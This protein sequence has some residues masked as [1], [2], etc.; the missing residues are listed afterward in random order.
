MQR[1]PLPSK[2]AHILARPSCWVSASPQSHGGCR[3]LP[4]RLR[5]GRQCDD[6]RWR[7]SV[8]QPKKGCRNHGATFRRHPLNASEVNVSVRRVRQRI[9]GADRQ[10]ILAF[11]ERILPRAS[12]LW[13]Q[14]SL[15]YRQRLQA[16]FFPEGIAYDGNRFN[17]TAA[18]APL[19][20]Y[21]APSESADERVVSRVG[22]EPT[23]RRLR[24]PSAKRKTSKN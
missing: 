3:G 21:L 7:V 18:T 20:N 5:P 12:D 24:V 4:R 9:S 11:A 6:L 13:V 15:D 16:L 22:I 19:F 2:A 8:D 17:R 1:L 23:T 10:G 14:A